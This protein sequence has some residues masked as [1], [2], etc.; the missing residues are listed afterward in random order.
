MKL[1]VLGLPE[2]A[3]AESDI[4][5]NTRPRVG[6]AGGVYSNCDDRENWN[7]GWTADAEL[8]WQGLY[9]SA[10]FVWFKNGPA[11]SNQFGY[12]ERCPG[13][14]GPDGNPYRFVSVGAHAQVGYVLPEVLFPVRQQALEVLARFDWVNPNAPFDSE[15]KILGGDERH[16]QYVAPTEL[17]DADNAPT[18][19]RMTFGIN[20][21]PTGQQTLRLQLNYQINRELED[22]V[23]TEGDIVGVR[24]EVLWLQITA[25]L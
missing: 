20:W 17:N 10:S 1:H 7:R 16:P 21:Y 24:N 3:A 18:R 12:G 8:R 6:I 15:N 13:Q 25:G 9:A 11:S 19:Y 2:G 5:R 23:T 14:D 4:A 22:I